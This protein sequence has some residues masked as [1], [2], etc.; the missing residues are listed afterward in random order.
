MYYDGVITAKETRTTAQ[1][2][3]QRRSS[4]PMSH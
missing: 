2:R 1:R 3:R 4:G